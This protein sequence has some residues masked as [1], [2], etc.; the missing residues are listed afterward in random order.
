MSKPRPWWVVEALRH[1][2]DLDRSRRSRTAAGVSAIISVMC[3]LDIVVG[4]IAHGFTTVTVLLLAALACTLVAW[5]LAHR[6]QPTLAGL[7]IAGVAFVV[8][9]GGALLT[10][11]IATWPIGVP[12]TALIMVFVLPLRWAPT[13]VVVSGACLWLFIPLGRQVTV[14]EVSPADLV[15]D[16]AIATLATVTI[17][18]YGALSLVAVERARRQAQTQAAAAVELADRD[19]L[20]GLLNRRAEQEQLP[21]LLRQARAQGQ[22]M[23]VAMIDV[24]AFKDVNDRWGHATGDDVLRTVAQVVFAQ[25][26]RSDAV[27]R[28]GGDEFILVLGDTGRE[29]ALVV[30]ER[31]RQT[32]A[33]H[34]GQENGAR[35]TVSIGVADSTES[36]DWPDLV[37]RADVRLLLAKREGRNQVV[38]QG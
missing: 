15:R 1:E 31:I 2:D 35:V 19:G 10:D 29:D 26:R 33:S 27:V 12:V 38:G 32:V 25:S 18:V 4:L 37:R 23:S 8:L 20:T 24:D 11:S 30:C 7:L 28:H 36:T 17:G 13:V 9:F 3:A 5:R 34:V 14:Q 21:A 22:V 16:S 6:E